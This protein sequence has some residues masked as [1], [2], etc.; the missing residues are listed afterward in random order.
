M[1]S[2]S[3][4]EHPALHHKIACGTC[5]GCEADQEGSSSCEALVEDG[6]HA[7]QISLTVIP[8]P[9]QD[10]RGLYQHMYVYNIDTYTVHVLYIICIFVLFT[11]LHSVVVFILKRV[12]VYVHKT[13]MGGLYSPCREVT[14][15]ALQPYLSQ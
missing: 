6:P 2:I 9:Q 15:T 11:R 7:P 5:C 4:L 10:L 3:F 8:L 1:Q 12:Y 13:I 14:H